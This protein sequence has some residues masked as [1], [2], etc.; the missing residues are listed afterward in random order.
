MDPGKKSK[1]KFKDYF[2]LNNYLPN[3]KFSKVIFNIGM[4]F[5]LLLI[6]S[7][8]SQLGFKNPKETYNLVLE[9]PQD[10]YMPCVNKVY[11]LCNPQGSVY[12]PQLDLCKNANPKFY[13]NPTLQPGETVGNHIFIMDNFLAITL[14]V[15]AL[16][17]VINH[18]LYNKGYDFDKKVRKDD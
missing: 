14:L 15:M 12:S 9:C 17:F 10:A 3:Y 16:C 7:V 11:E 5:L 1:Y 18:L 6:I 8:W 13:Q 2:D 4:I